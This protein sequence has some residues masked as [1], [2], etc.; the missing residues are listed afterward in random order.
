MGHLRERTSANQAVVHT[1][2]TSAKTTCSAG[3]TASGNDSRSVRIRLDRPCPASRYCGWVTDDAFSRPNRPPVSRR[4][5]KPAEPIWTLRLP[6]ATWSAELRSHGESGDWETLMLHDSEL[7]NRRR[8][9][10]EEERK[11][12]EKGDA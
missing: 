7:V 10:A 3:A 4:P 11:H 8:F 6:H 5:P 9:G 2:S 1:R 12:I